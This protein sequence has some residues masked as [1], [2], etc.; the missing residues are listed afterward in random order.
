MIRAEFGPAVLAL[1]MAFACPSLGT[2]WCEKPEL[3]L[4]Q[5]SRQANVISTYRRHFAGPRFSIFSGDYK[6]FRG[7]HPC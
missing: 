2:R 6:N 7:I 3:R 5:L 1:F 4:F